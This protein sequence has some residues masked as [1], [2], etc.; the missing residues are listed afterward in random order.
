MN[1]VFVVDIG[2]RTLDPI[3]A[4]AEYTVPNPCLF[5][6]IMAGPPPL[7]VMEI[8]ILDDQFSVED[9]H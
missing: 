2:I 3:A 6:I 7:A 9:P 4:C 5:A 8:M 1:C